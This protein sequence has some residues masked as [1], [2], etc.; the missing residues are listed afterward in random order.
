MNGQL[1]LTSV[2]TALHH[3]IRIIDVAPLFLLRV[4]MCAPPPE[5]ESFDRRQKQ[6]R[7]YAKRWATFASLIN[8]AHRGSDGRVRFAHA[9]GYATSQT[10]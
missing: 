10:R 2:S 3:L 1:Q 5:N 4:G 6:R 8:V 7:A 9:N